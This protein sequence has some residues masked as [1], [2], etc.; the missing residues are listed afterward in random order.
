MPKQRYSPEFNKKGRPVFNFKAI[1]RAVRMLMRFYPVLFP[2][3]CVLTIF[4]SAI[5]AVPAIFTRNIIAIISRWYE[6]G[7]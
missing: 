1:M 4:S 2:A 7:D 6:S 3:I 5:A